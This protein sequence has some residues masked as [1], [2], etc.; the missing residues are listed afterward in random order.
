[1]HTGLIE[2]E[3][4]LGR[5]IVDAAYKVHKDLGPV[6]LEKIYEACFCYGLEKK[7][8]PFRRQVDLHFFLTAINLTRVY[9][10]MY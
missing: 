9:V 1:M 3:E 10:L 4:Y 5:E 7:G 2:R 6:L 8:I